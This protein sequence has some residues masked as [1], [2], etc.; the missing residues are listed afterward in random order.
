MEEEESL[1]AGAGVTNL[2]NAIDHLVEVL[3]ANSI[4]ITGIVV[5]RILLASYKLFRA[6][7]LTVGSSADLIDN[8]WLE[9]NKHGTR[10]VLASSSLA[11]EGVERIV[12]TSDSFVAWHLTIGLDAMF[13]AIQLPAGIAHLD[14]CLAN[15]DTNTFTLKTKTKA[16]MAGG[17]M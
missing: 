9:I 11:E 2:T 15:M 4:M 5:S 6:E 7:Q 12:T 14:A 13:E 17:C 16:D 8:S 10:H 3:I 1:K